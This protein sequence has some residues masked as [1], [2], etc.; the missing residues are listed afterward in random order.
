MADDLIASDVIAGASQSR[1]QRF[2]RTDVL[3]GYLFS[4][5]TSD[6]LQ[7]HKTTD[8]G[9]TWSTTQITPN[10]SSRPTAWYER[11]TPGRTGGLIYLAYMYNG[12]TVWRTVDTS[13]DSLGSVNTCYNGVYPADNPLTL[14]ISLSRGGN[15]CVAAE[16]NSAGLQDRFWVG[17]TEK[18]TVW[19]GQDHIILLPGNE[20]DNN[21]IYALYWD[22]SANE[23]SI[24]HYDNSAN[25]WSETSIS[26]S[27]VD[28][29][30]K[31][32]G[33]TVRHS[34]NHIFLIAWTQIGS[35]TA[36][37]LCWEISDATTITART[38]VITNVG[39]A[40]GGISA[41]LVMNQVTGSLYA[42]YSHGDSASTQDV[43]YKVSTDGGVSWGAET[44]YSDAQT[45]WHGIHGGVSIDKDGG[46]IA[47]AII[48]E[49]ADDWYN[50]VGNGLFFGPIS[51]GGPVG[52]QQRLLLA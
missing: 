33:A 41:D 47:P 38:D 13:D 52:A 3:T 11:W 5:D 4:I 7:M 2:V 20:A 50:N 46:G 22:R 14:S 28:S 26:G 30:L 48:D 16:S 36:D 31:Q 25:T 24:K 43:Y 32:W 27:M 19:D 18:T 23:I 42:F 34:D 51:G 49:T 17:T 10:N 37:V 45:R 39:G 44:A 15:V 35:T 9:S 29:S 21:D 12:D 8:K 40:Y 6:R 1:D